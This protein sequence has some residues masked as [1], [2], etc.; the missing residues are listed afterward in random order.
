MRAG[1]MIVLVLALAGALS[2]GLAAERSASDLGVSQL[3]PDT[4]LFAEARAVQRSAPDLFGKSNGILVTRVDAGSQAESA[5]L[6]RGDVLIAYDG[7]PLQSL[8]HLD[9]L[10]AATPASRSLVVR[11]LRGHKAI[12]LRFR[13]GR[14]GI[15][16][17]DVADGLDQRLRQIYE[18]GTVEAK[19]S[20]HDAALT[21][22][23]QG[24]ALA[25]RSGETGPQGMFLSNICN[26]YLAMRQLTLA[27]ERCERALEINQQTGLHDNSRFALNNIGKIHRALGHGFYS[28]KDYRRALGSYQKA[29][30]IY[31]EL[32]DREA[33]GHTLVN[34]G[35]ALFFQERKEEALRSYQEALPILRDFKDERS[36]AYVLGLIGAIQ[37]NLRQYVESFETCGMAVE[38][39]RKLGDNTKEGDSLV[40]MAENDWALGRF[41]PALSRYQAAL[42]IRASLP[43]QR[44]LALNRVAIA[45]LQIF[46]KRY[47][48]GLESY[49]A[50]FAVHQVL[51]DRSQQA[52]DLLG[53]GLAYSGIKR[54]REGLPSFEQSAAIHKDIG[55]G[56]R[57]A[58]SLLAMSACLEELKDYD[59]AL[60]SASQA[61]TVAQS[62]NERDSEVEVLTAIAQIHLGR[63]DVAAA[64]PW[65]EKVQAVLP[66][67][68]SPHA[69]AQR[70]FAQ[71]KSAFYAEH[72]Q[73]AADRAGDAAALFRQLPEP[74][75]EAQAIKLSADALLEL[76]QPE[77]AR[78]HYEQALVYYQSAG[79]LPGELNARIGLGRCSREEKQLAQAVAAQEDVIAISRK[80]ALIELE[81]LALT[82]LGLTL[83]AMG[84][85][86][87]ALERSKQAL[88]ISER[89]NDR[90]DQADDLGNIANIYKRQRLFE[91][92]L[93]YYD[94]T[95]AAHR[96]IKRRKAV[97]IDLS[98]RGSIFLELGRYA[99]A[100]QSFQDALLISGEL[101]DGAGKVR[102]LRSI[103][104]T[105]AF[106]GR[107]AEALHYREEALKFA[108]LVQNSASELAALTDL[109]A[110]Q[111]D[112]DRYN[113]GEK[114]LR[115]ALALADRLHDRDRQAF[116]LAN[117]GAVSENRAQYR[118]ALEQYERAFDLNRLEQFREGMASNGLD[119]ANALIRS[120][121]HG[122]ALDRLRSV[123][124]L[125]AELDIADVGWR[126]WGQLSRAWDA[127]GNPALTILLGK[128][129]INAIQALRERNRGADD[130][131]QR[132][133]VGTKDEVYRTLAALLIQQQRFPEAQEVLDM[134]KEAELYDYLARGEGFDPR[135]TR[136]GYNTEEAAWVAGY[137]KIAADLKTLGEELRTLELVIPQARTDAEKARIAALAQQRETLVRALDAS[138]DDLIQRFGSVTPTDQAQLDAAMAGRPGD[139]RALLKTLASSSRS[140]TALVQYLVTDQGVTILLTTP[141]GW[142]AKTVAVERA[143]LYRELADLSTALTDKR[144]LDAKPP[145][146]RVYDRLVAPIE[147]ELK[148]QGI[149]TLLAGLDDRLRYLP[150][151]ALYDGQQWLAERFALV[152][153]TPASE[154]REATPPERWRVAGL[155]TTKGYRVNGR[156]FADLPAVRRELDGIVRRE[157]QAG[158]PGLLPGIERLDKAFTAAALREAATGGYAVVHIAS[159]FDL[160]PG[161]DRD[162]FLL[163]GTGEA[164]SL[165]DLRTQELDLR[166]VDLFT[167][168][169]C[170]T[171]LGGADSDGTEI[172]GLGGIVQRQGAQGVIASL[173][174]VADASTAWLMR[175]FY[176][177][178]TSDGL[179]KAAA[180][181]GAQ[182]ALMGRDRGQVARDLDSRNAAG[183]SDAAGKRSGY[184]KSDGGAAAAGDGRRGD[185]RHPYFWA[186]FILMGNWL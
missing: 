116:L 83:H 36:Q 35:D 77:K 165:H 141:D 134:R 156:Q 79:E 15:D 63:S 1:S 114:T 182:V 3:D 122:A 128:L 66:D 60:T 40:C 100:L 93:Q 14:L 123:V 72:F 173:W 179:D 153:Y 91:S 121:D 6:V 9:Q 43:D 155:G 177:L 47:Q 45:R 90:A 54:C 49:Q 37:A 172:E 105:Y 102:D 31:V 151:A 139:K 164:L 142:T 75:N 112:L 125:Q 184:R 152:V 55:D 118:E 150:L 126:L 17:E 30:A 144:L 130:T 115:A 113:D 85:L 10:T 170:E 38:L 183:G 11:A 51:D 159:H 158:D 98:N 97:A 124:G 88:A 143:T 20:L 163:L 180:L 68:L 59:R 23:E 26:V 44:A 92:A 29:N 78:A 34:V 32:G 70:S 110:S 132:A 73:Q 107:P 104:Q 148:A 74:G 13:G 71:A 19:Q 96:D 50:A 99:D 18:R 53:I 61:L 82:E 95:L 154:H 27:L 185:Y 8:A 178:R 28:E 106:L 33:A 149:R 171:A 84:R 22:L 166:Q 108:R 48:E 119:I 161:Q 62:A 25:Q 146:Q 65:L 186:P 169:A 39:A 117:L 46:L 7:K 80:Q 137:D 87:E 157:D 136:A 42:T 140:P 81:G 2:A 160:R 176:E 129:S 174:P 167:L 138:L 162:S 56:H 64:L 111:L 76:G 69:R 67:G 101:Q 133:F 94:R 58:T 109:G 135:R 21:T 89:L 86:P 5:G 145:A 57:A 181:S 168:S 4:A 12:E 147:P 131:N 103:G 175:R 41:E 52:E 24:L 16:A 127:Q 120:G